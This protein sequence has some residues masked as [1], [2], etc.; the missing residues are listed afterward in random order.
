[1]PA[2]PAERKPTTRISLRATGL[3]LGS[4]LTVSLLAGCPH[5]FDSRADPIPASTDPA[6]EREYR[7]ARAKLESGRPDDAATQYHEFVERHPQDQL[8]RSAKI[9][10]A[11][12]RL[13]MGEPAEA[14]ALL[15]PIARPD[16]PAD[17]KGDPVQSRARFLLGTALVE[18]GE[19]EKGRA[20]LNTFRDVPATSEDEVQLHALFA[21]AD[22]GLGDWRPALAELERFWDAARP[23]ERRYIVQ[24]AKEAAS[25]LSA[26]EAER[27]W[28]G[29][30][31]TLTTAFVGAKVAAD[32]RQ[33]GDTAGA[34]RIEDEVQGALGKLGLGTTKDHAPRRL[35]SE[36]GV[37]LPLTGKGKALGERALRGAL[38]GAELLD[39]GGNGPFA[40]D[41]RDTGS[42]PARA[43]AAIEELA[44][45]GV[46]AIVGPPDRAGATEAAAADAPIG[47]PL[48][49]LGPD[50]GRPA[51]ALFHVARAR[52]DAARKAAALIAEDGLRRVAVLGPDGASGKELARLFVEAAKSRGLDVVADVKFGDAAT[53]F[54]REVRQIE[55]ARPQAI[56]LPAT[57]AQLDLVAPQLA[58]SGLVAMANVK[59]TGHEARLY[60]T[61]DGLSPR[62]LVRSGKYLGGATV[63][64]PFWADAADP[65]AAQFSERYR[66]AYGEDP[67]VLDALAYDAVRA[68][69]LVVS[70]RG[71]PGSWTDVEDGLRE[72]DATGLTGPLGYR[73]DGQRAGEIAAWIVDGTTLRLRPPAKQAGEKG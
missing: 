50:D 60:A 58:S 64:P 66:D 49:T 27:A 55:A 8:V 35:K 72:L 45:A 70:Q 59:A 16:E 31:K 46:L 6:I 51:V 52:S 26:E 57:A 43:R 12:A 23:P 32:H 65:R 21:A 3:V 5:R 24:R 20:L 44:K 73:A 39:G 71:E 54:V 11:R 38:L 63:L 61:A 67:T 33:M 19:Y 2:A 1:M 36:V 47:A 34:Q 68:L 10:E 13:A 28:Q 14:R 62:N 9:G 7:E 22:L 37:V 40:V 42:D 69:R 56:F 18:S 30:R 4:T 48:F 17:P 25:H 41:V 29:D 15:E 53:T